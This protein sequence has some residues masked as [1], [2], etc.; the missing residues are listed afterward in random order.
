MALRQPRNGQPS[1]RLRRVVGLYEVCCG[2]GGIIA[3]SS[4][5]LAIAPGIAAPLSLFAASAIAGVALASGAKAGLRFSVLVQLLQVVGWVLPTSAWRFASGPFIG[6]RLDASGTT[7]Y[8][9]LDFTAITGLFRAAPA[10]AAV[11]FNLV[12]LAIIVVLLG[13]VR[14]EGKRLI[15]T[16][17]TTGC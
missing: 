14:W 2:S 4:L 3:M 13:P 11:Y 8:A 6:A 7:L 15:A 9:G 12:P 1:G 17:S 10:T 16:G 5:A